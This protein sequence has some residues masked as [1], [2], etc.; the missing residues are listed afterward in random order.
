V[1]CWNV[2]GL[3]GKASELQLWLLENKVDLVAIQE[4]Q[5]SAKRT[6]RLNGFQ[7]PVI[8]KRKSG[9]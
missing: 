1:I 2:A 7:Y 3:H 5:F 9:R 4:A 8:T 6:V